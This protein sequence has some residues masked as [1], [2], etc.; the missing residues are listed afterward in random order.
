[1]EQQPS[2]I[3]IDEVDGVCTK[4][5]ESETSSNTMQ[6][7]RD[8][9]QSLWSRLK[10]NGD[11]V[12]VIGSTNHPEKID[13]AFLRRFERRFHVPLPD[14]HLRLRFLKAALFDVLHTLN[15]EQVGELAKMIPSFSDDDILNCVGEADQDTRLELYDSEY[16]VEVSSSRAT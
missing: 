11:K 2:I 8:L 9:M 3:Y 1:M 4:Q 10:A 6:Q 7:V 16:W 14:T 15:E 5:G 12:T 13:S